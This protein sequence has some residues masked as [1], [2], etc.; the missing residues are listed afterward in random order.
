[1]LLQQ[2]HD[3]NMSLLSLA[4]SFT[5]SGAEKTLCRSLLSVGGSGYAEL[6]SRGKAAFS[7]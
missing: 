3:Y 6:E 7:P 1:M 2:A 4:G 5:L